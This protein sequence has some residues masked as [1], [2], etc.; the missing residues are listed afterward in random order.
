MTVLVVDDA[1]MV[2]AVLD[3]A[4]QYLGVDVVVAKNG[5]EAA[6]L[7]QTHPISIALI[8][9]NMP[10]MNGPETL[11]RLQ[12]QRPVPCVFMTGGTTYTRDELLRLGACAVLEKPFGSFERVVE[13]LKACFASEEIRL[14]EAKKSR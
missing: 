8:D 5:M 7:L 14:S 10:G 6:A 11:K 2:R 1:P 9:V 4:L 3:R 13:I 12:A